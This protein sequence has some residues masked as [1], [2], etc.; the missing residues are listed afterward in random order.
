MSSSG[1]REGR[2]STDIGDLGCALRSLL[3]SALM[4]NP[5]HLSSLSC[6]PTDL[7]ETA[8]GPSARNRAKMADGL[9]G[10]MGRKMANMARKSHFS[11]IFGGFFPFFGHF[12]PSSLVRRKSIFRPFFPDFG[13]K[14]RRQSLAGQQ[15]LLSLSFALKV[16]FELEGFLRDS[17]EYLEWP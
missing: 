15:D 16:T 11:A 9:T 3:S 4:K 14:A 2:S 13:P 8:F 7:L 1:P 17:R 12:F 10:E 5:K 6:V